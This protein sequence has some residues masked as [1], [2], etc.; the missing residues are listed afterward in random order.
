M[1]L[2]KICGITNLEDAL[3]ASEAGADALGFVFY[4]KSPRYVEPSAARDIIKGLPP[5]IVT[6]GVFADQNEAEIKEIISKSNI[7]IAQLHGDEPPEFC[8]KLGRRIIK[9]IRVRNMESLTEIK[10]YRAC[11]LLLDTYDKDLKGGT[12]RI[13]NWEIAREARIFNK[14]IIAG[15]LTPDNVSEAIKV[16]QPYAVDVSS[17]VEKEKG[18]KDHQKIKLF[19]ERAKH[20]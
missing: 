5:F 8:E 3:F 4:K 17:G 13:F 10:K 2:V 9:A 20:R 1:V 19:I 14:V 12:G 18:I 16:A 7:D 11:A 15:G 6:V